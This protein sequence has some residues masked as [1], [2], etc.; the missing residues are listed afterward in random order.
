MD[1]SFTGHAEEQMVLRGIGRELVIK[2]IKRGSK[3]E[4][5]D[6]WLSIYSYVAVAYKIRGN[7][8]IIK[9]VMV[10]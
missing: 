7:R 8:Y 9:T 10:I 1:I 5:T 6:G 4:Q 2:T 3:A